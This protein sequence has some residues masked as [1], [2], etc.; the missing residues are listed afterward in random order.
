[1][2]LKLSIH[3]NIIYFHSNTNTRDIIIDQV[4]LSYTRQ[5]EKRKVT[6]KIDNCVSK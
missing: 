1:V 4:L 2:Y 6:R 5:N 3:R